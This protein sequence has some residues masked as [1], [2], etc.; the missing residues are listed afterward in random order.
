MEGVYN[1]FIFF[2][3]K[4]INGKVIR[5]LGNEVFFPNRVYK[6]VL[7]FFYQIKFYFL[8]VSENIL[9]MNTTG[10][11]SVFTLNVNKIQGYYN[12]L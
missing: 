8:V 2:T 3:L 1:L 12:R 7:V 5:K 6:T 4:K 10:S 11:A 9:N